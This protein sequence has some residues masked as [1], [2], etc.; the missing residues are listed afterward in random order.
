MRVTSYEFF[1]LE[2]LLFIQIDIRKS[3]FVYSYQFL[4]YFC[5]L[6]FSSI[7]LYSTILIKYFIFFYV[8][9][10]CFTRFFVFI[11]VLKFFIKISRVVY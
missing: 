8:I 7:I 6:K 9:I 4:H 1:F 2:N 10:L 11:A 5:F 3:A